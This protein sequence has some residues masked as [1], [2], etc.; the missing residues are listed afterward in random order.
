MNMTEQELK[1]EVRWMKRVTKDIYKTDLSVR[2][3]W[4]PKYQRFIRGLYALGNEASARDSWEEWRDAMDLCVDWN[5]KFPNAEI[6]MNEPY[7]CDDMEGS[8][9]HIEDETFRFTF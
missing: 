9:A 6:W 5:R 3:N 1:K 8:E 7:P 2:D 4:H